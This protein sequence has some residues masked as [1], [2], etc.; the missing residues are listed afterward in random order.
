MITRIEIENFKSLQKVDLAL[1]NLNLFV[2]TNASGKSNFFDALRLLQG[3]GYG[4]TIDEIL[5][6]KP[7]SAGSEVWEGIRGGSE[8]VAFD[9]PV[10][11]NTPRPEGH[12]DDVVVEQNDAR[13]MRVRL[14]IL[15]DVRIAAELACESGICEY[16]ISI[17]TTRGRLRSESLRV[18]RPLS[19]IPNFSP[20]LNVR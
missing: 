1:G 17:A 18:I 13:H 15:P 10:N 4:F 12:V 8:R 14:R 2:G 9:S 20:R 11:R 7:K 3:I 19:E 6:G 5:N 16:A